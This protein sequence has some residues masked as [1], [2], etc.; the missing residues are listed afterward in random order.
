MTVNTTWVSPVSGTL[1]KSAGGTIDETMTDAL[2]S[3]FYHLGGAAGYIGCRATLASAQSIS[4]TTDTAIGLA[5]ESFDSDP[6]GAMHDTSTNNSRI[7]CKTA[8][9]YN[10]SGFA[11]FAAN[12]T[13]TRKATIKVNGSTIIAGDSKLACTE[14]GQTTYLTL[15]QSYSFNANDYV[16]L[17]V[18]QASGGA[19]N[20]STAGLSM[21]KA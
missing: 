18:Y 19:L 6:N 17:Y 20:C 7:V 3:N 16:E 14:G 5:A 12:G 15:A 10:V 21:M 2:A 9:V 1:D 8:G 11:E 13:S 4:N